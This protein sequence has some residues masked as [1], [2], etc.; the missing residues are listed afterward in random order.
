MNIFVE[1][2]STVSPI[3]LN[4]YV[5]AS[6]EGLKVVVPAFKM[7]EPMR[8]LRVDGNPA[9]SLV[10]TGNIP[11]GIRKGKEFAGIHNKR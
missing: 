5:S 1:N 4:D 3:S 9:I 11:D 2:I 8:E 6:I 10:Y 7:I